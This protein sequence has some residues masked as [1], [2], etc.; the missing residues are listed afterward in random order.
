MIFDND[1]LSF[2]IFGNF[3]NDFSKNLFDF[4]NCRLCCDPE[5]DGFVFI[6]QLIAAIDKQLMEVDV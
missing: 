3:L 6:T 5:V 2:Q 4:F 1:F